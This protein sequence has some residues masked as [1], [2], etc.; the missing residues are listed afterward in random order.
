MGV[1][2]RKKLAVCCW[3]SRRWG[4]E[5]YQAKAMTEMLC[6]VV[7]VVAEGARPIA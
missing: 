2:E 3:G 1:Q 7:V 5:G 6:V 4:S